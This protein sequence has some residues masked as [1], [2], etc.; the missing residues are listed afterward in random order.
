MSLVLTING[1]VNT[2]CHISEQELRMSTQGRRMSTE[3]TIRL[4]DVIGIETN[5]SELNVSSDQSKATKLNLLCKVHYITREKLIWKQETLFVTG[6]VEE[7]E[8][9]ISDLQLHFKKVH[10]TRPKRLLVL[11]NPISGGRY[12]QSNSKRIIP[13]FELA[14][15]TCDV[16]VSEREKHFLEIVSRYDFTTVDGI[17]IFGGDGSFSEVLCNLLRVTHE[18]AGL[19]YNDINGPFTTNPVPIGLIP[20]GTGNGMS[21][22]EYGNN[23]MIT[24]ALHIIKGNT[25]KIPVM[26]EYCDDELLGYASVISAY[27]LFADMLY[28]IDQYRWMRRARYLFGIIYWMFMK[29]QRLF[30]AEITLTGSQ[31]CER[32]D[33]EG[34]TTEEKIEGEFSAV[35]FIPAKSLGISAGEVIVLLFHQTPKS[36]LLRLFMTMA[37]R[38]ALRQEDYPTILI[39]QPNSVRVKVNP[40]DLGDTNFLNYIMHIDGEI[41]TM[42]KAELTMKSIPDAVNVFSSLHLYSY[43]DSQPSVSTTESTSSSRACA[44]DT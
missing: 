22:I 40:K 7:C 43:P 30:D 15:I 19:D 24:A 32:N 16:K 18:K 39:R 2:D 3:V 36:H 14:G 17:V 26:A 34:K 13:L 31:L 9:F 27:G 33:E 37:K 11:V 25:R 38:E 35:G 1:K 29:S 44:S 10:D 8:R 23:D 41:Q 21:V 42:K 12:G 5:E 28:Y 4:D 20:S 6:Q